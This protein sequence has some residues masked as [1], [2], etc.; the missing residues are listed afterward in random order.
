MSLASTSASAAEIPRIGARVQQQQAVLRPRFNV[1]TT[2]TTRAEDLA[3]PS[4][5]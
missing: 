3:S 5:P 4:L 1:R 2:F